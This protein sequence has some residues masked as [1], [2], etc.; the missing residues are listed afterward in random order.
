MRFER[1][2]WVVDQELIN[3]IAET[4]QPLNTPSHATRISGVIPMLNAMLRASRFLLVTGL[5]LGIMPAALSAATLH[6]APNGNDANPGTE[7][8]P[9]ATIEKARTSRPHN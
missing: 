3:T 2:S 9:F 8:Q 6:V 5:L 7:S 1:C 4:N